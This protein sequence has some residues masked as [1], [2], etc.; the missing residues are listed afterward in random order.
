M[1]GSGWRR[2]GRATALVL[3]VALAVGAGTLLR[4]H[5][6]GPD[7]V[8]VTR[9]ATRAYASG[10]CQALRAVSAH[11]RQ[12]SC[13]DVA[14]V[15]DAYRDEGLRP[16]TF[17]YDVVARDGD[18]ATVR[19]TYERDDLLSQEIVELEREDG[20]WKVLLVPLAG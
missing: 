18:S 6:A 4:R 17:S 19:I 14:Q 16:E 1:R 11:P 12:V 10:D 5:L 20:A 8:A 7:P 9:A 13:A 15:R 3:A 2:V